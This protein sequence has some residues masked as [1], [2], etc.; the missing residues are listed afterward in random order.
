MANLTP[1]KFPSPPQENISIEAGLFSQTVPKLFKDGVPADIRLLHFDADIYMS[2]RPILDIVA[3]PLNYRYYIL[4]DE[5][6]SA[7]HEFKAWMEFVGV[8]KVDRWRV[9]A[10]SEDGFQVLIELNY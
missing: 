10:T 7:N 3:G 1:G 9:V 2:T 6:Y 8:Y 4:F 5:F